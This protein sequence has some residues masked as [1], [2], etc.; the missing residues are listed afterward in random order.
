MRN[1]IISLIAIGG[2]YAVEKTSLDRIPKEALKL[3]I[4]VSAEAAKQLWEAIERNRAANT[5]AWNDLNSFVDMAQKCG[6][7]RVL[8][9]LLEI[10]SILLPCYYMEG[11]DIA[12]F[13][14]MVGIHQLSG[15]AAEEI[16]AETKKLSQ[17]Y[18][19]VLY[20]AETDSL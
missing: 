12:R 16:T 5:P 19:I 13:C 9:V 2:K 10:N 3:S 1:E 4:D 8:L 7:R 11:G 15:A 6:L 14:E 20:A 18:G 17:V